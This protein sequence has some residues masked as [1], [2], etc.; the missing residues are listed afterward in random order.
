M[1][2]CIMSQVSPLS[3]EGLQST[4]MKNKNQLSVKSEWKCTWKMWC[5]TVHCVKTKWNLPW[6]L[7]RTWSEKCMR[8]TCV[9]FSFMTQIFFMNES[10][11]CPS[12]TPPELAS[13]VG[14]S[15][16]WPGASGL[17]ETSASS[18]PLTICLGQTLWPKKIEDLK[19]RSFEDLKI[20]CPRIGV[21]MYGCGR[22][23]EFC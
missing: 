5:M 19:I 1:T 16:S 12:P 20:W 22:A 9:C 8:K 11:Q 18:T 14:A 21:G 13:E 2:P 10:P 23:T 7:V 3:Q 6:I 17:A 15:S 4:L